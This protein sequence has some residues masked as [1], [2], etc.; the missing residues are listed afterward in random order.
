VTTTE[1]GADSDGVDSDVA[2]RDGAVWD[3]AVW[4]G[5]EWTA[6]AGE[7]RSDGGLAAGCR[8]ANGPAIRRPLATKTRNMASDAIKVT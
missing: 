6:C 1:A 8:G 5:A 3:G 2:A 4:D 7:R